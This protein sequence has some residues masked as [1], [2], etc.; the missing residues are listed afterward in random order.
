MKAPRDERKKTSN[1]KIE[2]GPCSEAVVVEDKD[3]PAP[4]SYRHAAVRA[5]DPE[6][7]GRLLVLKPVEVARILGLHA[8]GPAAVEADLFFQEEV[9]VEKSASERANH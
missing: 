3:K 5:A 8:L 6:V 7:L 4:P 2:R 9:E 1:A